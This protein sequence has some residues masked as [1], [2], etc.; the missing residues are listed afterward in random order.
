MSEGIKCAGIKCIVKDCVNHTHEGKF[1]GTL[2]APCYQWIAERQ[3]FHS[4][5]YRNEFGDVMSCEVVEANFNDSK[6]T[7]NMLGESWRVGR[8]LYFLRPAVR[9]SHE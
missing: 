9:G 4:Q 6:V 3:G 1:V 2:C 5:A 8:G 7:L